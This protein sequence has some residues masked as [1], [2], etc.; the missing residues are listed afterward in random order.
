MCQVVLLFDAR[1]SATM[2]NKTREA[3]YAERIEIHTLRYRAGWSLEQI[4]EAMGFHRTTVS[5]ICW[6]P[7]TPQK[8]GILQLL[9]VNTC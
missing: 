9:D 4:A 6:Q 7:R 2:V 3:T 5:R 8:V 1:V